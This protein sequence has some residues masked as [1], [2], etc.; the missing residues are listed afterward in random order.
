MR[1]M[2]PIAESIVT[3]NR[4]HADLNNIGWNKKRNLHLYKQRFQS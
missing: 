3:G 2:T 4:R 1:S